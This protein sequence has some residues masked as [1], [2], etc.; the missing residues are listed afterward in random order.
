MTSVVGKPLSR[1]DG[2]LKVTGQ[3]K[4]AAEF[5][6]EGQAYAVVV[7]STAGLGRVETI[8]SSAVERM[9]GVLA[10]ISHL[11]AARLAY[12]PNR[13]RVDPPTGERLHVLQDPEIRFFGQPVAVIVAETLDQAEHAAHAL[14]VTYASR[15]PQVDAY[16]SARVVPDGGGRGHADIERGSADAAFAAA[17][18][19]VDA[20][21]VI[22]RQNHNPMEP[23]ATVAAWAGDRLTLWSKS[24]FVGNEQ[25]EIAAVFGLP[26]ENVQVICPF[27]GGA[28]GTSL[29]TWPHVTLAALAARHVKRPVKLVLTRRQMFFTTGHRPFTT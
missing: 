28:F 20:E 27:I 3:A 29:R 18:Y 25:A 8:D 2:R 9:P 24:Q 13:A 14:K 4:Y 12:N 21:F 22:Q 19:T 10:V 11:N 15:P 23:H 16:S 6:Q 17:K 5:N 1:V 7:G 26:K